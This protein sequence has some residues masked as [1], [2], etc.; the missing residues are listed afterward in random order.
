LLLTATAAHRSDLTTRWDVRFTFNSLLQNAT[1][2]I[3][4][5]RS[6]FI[7]LSAGEPIAEGNDLFGTSVKL[8]RRICDRAESAQVLV[9]DVV[10]QL[11]AGKEFSF[12][13]KGAEILKGF[14]EPVALLSV[15]AL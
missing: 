6:G 5:M 4:K 1:T 12:Q 8:A 13:P 10:R 7:G 3:Q 15:H 14:E 9:A 11:V 2:S